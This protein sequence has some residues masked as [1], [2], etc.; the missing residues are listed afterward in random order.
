MTLEIPSFTAYDGFTLPAIG[1]GTSGLRGGAAAEAV[2]HAIANGYRLIDSAF[3]Y[4]NEGAVGAGIAD[5]DAPRT[6]IIVT[7]KLPGRHHAYHEALAA[8]EESR[9]RLHVDAIDLELIHWPNPGRDRYVEAWKALVEARSRG[10]VRA[11]GV[12]NFLPEHLERIEDATGVRPAVNQIQLHPYAPQEEAVAYHRA[13]G[14]LTEAWSPLGRGTDALAEPALAEI[15]RAHDASVQQIV[16]AWH[17]ARGVVAIPKASG[18]AHQRA[19]LES[20]RI[21]LAPEEVERI[22]AL[23]ATHGPRPGTDPATVDQL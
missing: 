4:E 5:A 21:D 14:I 19:N 17:R 8:I 1:F 13:H 12:S 10:L 2:A 20:L 3:N 23:G 6:G 15:A 22:T 9:Y 16:L 11:I 7:T 18:D